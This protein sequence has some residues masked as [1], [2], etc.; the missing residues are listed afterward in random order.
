MTDHECAAC[1]GYYNP[2]WEPYTRWNHSMMGQSA[3][4]PVFYGALAIAELF[5]SLNEPPL[6]ST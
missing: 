2:D 3:R 6:P 1:H 4:D 5:A